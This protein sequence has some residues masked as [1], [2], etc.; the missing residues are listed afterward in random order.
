[1]AIKNSGS[2]LAFSEIEFE[3]GEA[4]NNNLGAYRI[5][6]TVGGLINQPLDT[7]IPQSV[8]V[9]SS[10]ISF[11][12]FYSKRLNVIID[13]YTSDANNP[14]DAREKYQTG[15]ASGNRTVIGFPATKDRI[16]ND[17]SGS[18]VRIHVNKN[19]GSSKGNVTHCAVRTGNEWETG[20]VL[21]VEVGSSGLISG[22]GGDGG[23]GGTSGGSEESVPANNGGNGTDGSSGLGIQYEGTAI[24]NNGS[25]LA[26]GGGGGGGGYRRLEK[27]EAWQGPVY[28]ANGGGGGGGQGIPNGSGGVQG[29][30]GTVEAY[31]DKGVFFNTTSTVV[32]VADVTDGVFRKMGIIQSVDNFKNTTDSGRSVGNYSI[33]ASE[34]TNE[35]A[36]N[37]TATFTITVGTGG[38]VTNVAVNQSGKGYV[39]NDT[40]TVTNNLGGGTSNF[41]FD[42]ASISE[43]FKFVRSDQIVGINTNGDPLVVGSGVG[44]KRYLRNSSTGFT[45]D[46]IPNV[47]VDNSPVNQ[48][49]RIEEQELETV[50][51]SGNA[52]ESG[53]NTAGGKGGNGGENKLAHGGGGGGGGLAGEGGRGGAGT[54]GEGNPTD[55]G[56]NG[57]DGTTSKGGNGAQGVHTG[58]PENEENVT[59]EG[60]TGGASGAAIRKTSGSITVT[61]SNAANS[62]LFGSNAQTG[63]VTGSQTATG[64]THA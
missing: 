27:E 24:I 42:V 63:S 7:G 60:G 61:I 38:V 14:A 39:V 4:P 57:A 9:G 21:S 22:A 8:A 23:A 16:V 3:F 55:N 53:S 18:K 35:G 6:Q 52:G 15:S 49:W 5:S 26:G 2:S 25:I 29:S 33:S 40:I 32:N 13:Y 62:T 37:N 48:L 45:N 10:Q 12:D 50:N 43:E 28:R 51:A 34:Y 46:G 56:N 47:Q 54:D 11:S 36:G 44:S 17:S 59:G 41:K 30:G 1:M 58:T 19:I 64:V 20:T 31:A